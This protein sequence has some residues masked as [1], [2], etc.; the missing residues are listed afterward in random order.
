MFKFFQL[1][2]ATFLLCTVALITKQ[3]SH[4]HTEFSLNN[5]NPKFALTRNYET[6]TQI[7]VR[8]TCSN[9]ETFGSCYV[10]KFSKKPLKIHTGQMCL[11][12]YYFFVFLRLF[13]H[14]DVLQTRSLTDI[15]LSIFLYSLFQLIHDFSFRLLLYVI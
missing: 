5:T 15:F 1:N 13:F 11:I 9:S 12:E 8:Y 4:T 7:N 2:A 6:V 10:L 14:A 3:S